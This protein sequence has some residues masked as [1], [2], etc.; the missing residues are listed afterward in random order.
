M[1]QLCSLLEDETARTKIH[2]LWCLGKIG[3]KQAIPSILNAMKDADKYVRRR[4]G[5]APLPLNGYR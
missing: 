3:D 2:V 4:A 1:T 5:T